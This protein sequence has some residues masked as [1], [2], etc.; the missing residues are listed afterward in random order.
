MPIVTCFEK[1]GLAHV[2]MD[3]GKA[4]AI[5]P[6]F[7]AA[8][9]NALDAA[10]E[11]RAVVL[12]GRPGRFCAG[13]DLKRL[14]TL[15]Q[16]EQVALLTDF[17][18]LTLRLLTFPR[19]VVAWVEGHAIA[20]GA[21]LLMA[22]DRRIGSTG[23]YNV[24]LSEVAIGIPMPSFVLELARCTL[25]TGSMR[26]AVLH[27]ELFTAEDAVTAGFLDHL[28]DEDDARAEA[29]K[30]ARLPE[31][32]YSTT[33]RRIYASVEQALRRLDEDMTEFFTPAARR[34]A[35]TFGAS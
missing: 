21:V 29:L 2:H 9:N 16:A 12:T 31:P 35:Q 7:L 15:P 11:A 3:D 13:L 8:V 19:P 17:G 28:G 34:H 25:P 1:D 10:A 32:A 27:G 23:E 24:G 4:N 33:K 18:R 5:N 20:G 6:E 22:C 30:L 26:P 14:P